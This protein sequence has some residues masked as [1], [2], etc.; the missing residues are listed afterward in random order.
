MVDET[1]IGVWMQDCPDPSLLPLMARYVPLESVWYVAQLGEIMG[2]G[3]GAVTFPTVAEQIAKALAARWNEFDDE[4]AHDIQQSLPRI[5]QYLAEPERGE[6]ADDNLLTCFGVS[7]TREAMRL[8]A[9][10]MRLTAA[11]TVAPLVD[12]VERRAFLIAFVDL[13]PDGLFLPDWQI[14]AMLVRVGRWLDLPTR[15]KWA[16]ALAEPYHRHISRYLDDLPGETLASDEW[17]VEDD[18]L[19]SHPTGI[20][21]QK[22]MDVLP[23]DEAATLAAR[24]VAEIFDRWAGAP[25]PRE[26]SFQLDDEDD[27][28]TDLP[29][30]ARSRSDAIA[31][32]PPPR[33][34]RRRSLRGGPGAGAAPDEPAA[35]I[36]FLEMD[37]SLDDLP[38][39]APSDDQSPAAPSTDRFPQAAIIHDQKRRMTFVAGARNEIVCW[40]GPEDMDDRRPR[41]TADQPVD[42]DSVP[43]EGLELDVLLTCG[44]QESSGK[45]WL[46]KDPRLRTGDC[47]LSIDVPE[48]ERFI[49][50]DIA[51]L[52]RGRAFEIIR[53]DAP[54][55]E[56]GEDESDG[57]LLRVRTQVQQ[58]DVIDLTDRE[59]IDATAISAGSELVL[60]GARGSGHFTL[61]NTDAAIEWLND[62]LFETDKSLVRGRTDADDENPVI[63]PDDAETLA[64]LRD[65]AIHGNSLY[66]ELVAQGFKDPGERIQLLNLEPSAYVPLE[67]VYDRGFPITGARLCDGWAEAL[68]G[69]TSRCPSCKLAEELTLEERDAMPTICPLGF[70]SLQKIIERF[71]KPRE[72]TGAAASSASSPADGD[73]VLPAITSALFASSFR[74]DQSD[75]DNTFN[76]LGD[77][78][79][80]ALRVDNWDAWKSQV[81]DESPQLIVA[82]PHH[83]VVGAMD[84][85]EIGDGDELSQG[86]MSRLYVT[87]STDKP[88][89]IVVLFGCETQKQG[90]MGY[91]SFARE[92]TRH[93]AAIVLGTMARVLGR[94]AA[95]VAQCLIRDLAN[96]GDQERFGVLMRRLRRRM[97]AR[98]YMMAFCLVALGDGDWQITPKPQE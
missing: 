44:D 75:R 7:S 90:K 38:M 98:G 83:S 50:A 79:D 57:A 94:H 53:I 60:F 27:A 76:V 21:I 19:L 37:D 33:R 14:A 72:E 68:A 58:R 22:R 5:A 30:P 11:A 74:V 88:G 78:F 52:F 91:V 25:P 96:V 70:W 36:V 3:G 32:S 10:G 28:S 95:P 85:L 24:A 12:D 45:V 23:A 71:D 93:R 4:V 8:V 55:L 82:L 2:G 89:P 46:P 65:L 15:T 39:A 31:S 41:A 29:L 40:I 16:T 9:P 61:Q 77:N 80:K 81:N 34:R 97:L 26:L 42:E 92:F 62:E 64:F 54:V 66:K 86:R 43:L 73:T 49:V 56:A 51:F 87:S 69:D 47:M 6:Q 35:D 13:T 63:D 1:D 67:F 18:L 48:D 17:D 59:P 84:A 20:E